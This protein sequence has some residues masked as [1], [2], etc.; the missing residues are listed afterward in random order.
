MF[1]KTGGCSRAGRQ[2]VRGQSIHWL[3]GPIDEALRH[4]SSAHPA[5]REHVEVL[6]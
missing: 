4:M 2:P 1:V 3:S 6:R 5:L